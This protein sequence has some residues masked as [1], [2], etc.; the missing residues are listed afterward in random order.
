[1]PTARQPWK[2]FIL[3][4][5]MA[6][7]VAFAAS[8]MAGC[9]IER[10]PAHLPQQGLPD[11]PGQ[12]SRGESGIVQ[13]RW[14]AQFSDPV[15]DDLIRE[16]LS[17]NP[18]LQYSAALWREAQ[19]RIRAAESY[20]RP[21]V[22]ATW[23]VERA[24]NGLASDA[25]TAQSV[26]V[27]MAW[28]LDVW[29]RI[30]HD[31]AAAEQASLAT[32]LDHAFARQSLAA[33]VAKAWFMAIEAGA[34]LQ[35]ARDLF[36]L[37][38]MTAEIT[39]ARREVGAG[40][41]LD[42]E[43]AEANVAL[44]RDEV[45]SS[46]LALEEAARALELLLGRYPEAELAVAKDFP[47]MPVSTPT[48]LPSQL[49]ERRPDVYAADRRVAA[50]FHRLESARAATLPTVG[51]SASLGSLLNPASAIWS[52]G[53]NLLAPIYYGGRFDAQV[54]VFDAQ[55]EQALAN[56]VEV[57]LTAF[58]EVERALAAEHYLLARLHALREANRRLRAASDIAQARYENGVISILDLSQVRQQA[59][60]ARA[61]LLR[62]QSELL[63]QRVNLHLALGGSFDAQIPVSPV[64]QAFDQTDHAS[65]VVEH[66]P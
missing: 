18:D 41:A 65:V 61:S 2:I 54:D 63:Q 1:M 34:Q 8:A 64:Q 48:G 33:A 59:F 37:Q 19:A 35:I 49:L 22:A 21:D 50:A 17:H 9:A 7:P 28:E 16:A 14:V 30:R 46:R 52:I 66:Q 42:A 38:Q 58:A 62:V 24:D 57:G 55:Q 12:F 13:D 27:S 39:R 25:D 43:I 31:V 26:G 47:A 51:L 5:A 3:R 53:A 11:V 10:I 40:L 60:S 20:L 6:L 45:E 4:A 29:G 44:A 56:Y 23:A 36:E 15:L 32:G